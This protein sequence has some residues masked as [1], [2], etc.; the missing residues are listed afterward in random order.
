MFVS[1][2]TGAGSPPGWYPS[3]QP[4]VLRYWDGQQWTNHVQPVSPLPDPPADAPQPLD[5]LQRLRP[6]RTG[7]V[8]GLVAAGIVVIA[9]IVAAA[10]GLSQQAGS[11]STADLNCAP[12]AELNAAW[13]D[14]MSSQGVDPDEYHETYSEASVTDIESEELAQVLANSCVYSAG[15]DDEESL[16]I[17]TFG[18]L[19]RDEVEVAFTDSGWFK[20]SENKDPDTDQS[21]ESPLCS[22]SRGECRFSA[23][24]MTHFIQGDPELVGGSVEVYSMRLKELFPDA[25][26]AVTLDLPY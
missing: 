18:P 15:I 16:L 4:G 6:R 2:T 23:D 11:S 1:D 21:W 3:E 20:D 12:V 5:S 8:I 26:F 25:T 19:K 17:V 22:G 13:S 24:E 14:F 9:G 10:W 7:V